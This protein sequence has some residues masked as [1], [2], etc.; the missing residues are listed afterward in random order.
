MILRQGMTLAVLG[1]MP[2]P[3]GAGAA[4]RLLETMLFEV[5]PADLPGGSIV[6]GAVALTASYIPARRATRVDPLAAS[7][8]E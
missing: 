4:A 1:M 6:L 2:G 5:Q 7:G 3:A 8:Q